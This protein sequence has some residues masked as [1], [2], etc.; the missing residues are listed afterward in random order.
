VPLLCNRLNLDV[1]PNVRRAIAAALGRIGDDSA[2]EV[3]VALLAESD[4][5]LLE[6]VDRS[7]Q[8]LGYTID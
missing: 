2:V 7:L 3:L 8:M 4:D 6:A 1:S 5:L